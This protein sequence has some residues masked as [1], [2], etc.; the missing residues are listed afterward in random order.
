MTALQQQTTLA[1][2]AEQVFAFVTNPDNFSAYVADYTNGRVTSEH[3][4]GLGSAFRWTSKMGPLSLEAEERVVDWEEPRRVVYEGQLA[5]VT[6]RSRMDVD[7][8][9]GG[10]ELRVSVDYSVPLSRGGRAVETMLQPLIARD[11]QRSLQQLVGRFGS[12]DDEP[13]K[14]ELVSIYRR[15]ANSYDY[16]VQLYRLLGFRLQTYRR[17]AVDALELQPGD[18]VVEIGCGTGENFGLLHDRVGP[19]GRIIGVDLTDAMLEQAARKGRTRG[20]EN[21]QLVCSDAAR[22]DFPDKVDAIL[23]TLALTHCPEYDTVIKRGAAALEPSGRWAVLDMK[24]PERWPS[25]VLDVGLALCRPFGVTLGAASR[26]PWE[27]MQNHLAHTRMRELYFGLAY[28]CV[29]SNEPF[30][31]R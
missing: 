8:R 19:S 27:S 7:E 11:I 29:G 10:S 20:Y 5:G 3:S 4:T 22:F 12:P 17:M 2:P 18:T 31:A 14:D 23:S 16:S 30:R 9:D 15:H 24:M 28:L 13:S 6:F 21:L 26:H 1:A 25:W